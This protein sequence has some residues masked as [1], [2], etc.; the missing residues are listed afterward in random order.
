MP[1][2]AE[3]P[4]LAEDAFNRRDLAALARL[5]APD[6]HYSAP[7]GEETSTREAAVAREQ[8]LLDAFPDIRADLGRHLVCG[9][10]LVIE[11]IMSGTHDGP[12][13]LGD[14]RIAATHRPMRTRFVGVFSFEAGLVRRE[15]VYYDRME[16]LQQLGVATA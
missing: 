15:R 1:G 12:L 3:Y 4:K 10:A 2:P 9:D 11:G 5:W 6:F 16:L 7:G 13:R 8:A 14:V